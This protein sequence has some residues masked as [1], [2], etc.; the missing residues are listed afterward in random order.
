MMTDY[1]VFT[2]F[3]QAAVKLLSAPP[4]QPPSKSMRTGGWNEKSN[5]AERDGEKMKDESGKMKHTLLDSIIHSSFI[6][7]PSSIPP[8]G[9]V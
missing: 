8:S 3:V 4:Y 5:P 1:I 9:I 2:V 7:H 6:F